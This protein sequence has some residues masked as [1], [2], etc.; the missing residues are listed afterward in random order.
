[1]DRVGK[2]SSHT[3]YT[4]RTS[5]RLTSRTHYHEHVQVQSRARATEVGRERAIPRHTRTTA[6]LPRLARTSIDDELRYAVLDCAYSGICGG[7]SLYC[8]RGHT[9]V[10]W[11][12]FSSLLSAYGRTG[13]AYPS[14]I[15]SGKSS[16]LL[17]ASTIV[18]RPTSY[19]TGHGQTRG[20]STEWAKTWRG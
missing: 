18:A 4:V 9:L 1:M 14:G 19:L 12:L 8:V 16:W 6:I 11:V 2:S 15:A 3:P 20:F 13:T 10:W 7:I 17:C 5:L